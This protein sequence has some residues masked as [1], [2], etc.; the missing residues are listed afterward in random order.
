MT[1]R[2]ISNI[3]IEQLYEHP[4][5][6]E[7][8]NKIGKLESQDLEKIKVP[9]VIKD[10]ILMSPGVWNEYFY[11]ADSI[12]DAFLKSEWSKKEVRSLFLDHED[13][14]SS[15]WIGEVINP[16]MKGDDLIGDLIIVDKP[17]AMKLAYGAKMGISP[18]V[19][20]GEEGG[21]MLQFK[22]DNFS[23]V[24]NPA[25]KTAY[26]NNQQKEV[27]KMAE[28]EAKEQPKEEA[29]TEEAEEIRAKLVEAGATV[30]LK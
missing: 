7:L 25:V 23:V 28:E 22:Y 11:S 12:H 9:Y 8:L 4:T 17:T 27:K 16:K 6:Q 24:I 1:A 29:K 19:S 30:E 13:A 20:G 14:R 15:E 10:K 21:K 18:K 2:T 5:V 3:P 26:I